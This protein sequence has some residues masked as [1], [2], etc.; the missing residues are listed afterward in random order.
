MKKFEK[1]LQYSRK[2]EELQTARKAKEVDEIRKFDI[3]LERQKCRDLSQILRTEQQQVKHVVQNLD[4]PVE[5]ELGHQA[6][7]RQAFEEAVEFER[8]AH[9]MKLNAPGNEFGVISELQGFTYEEQHPYRQ[10]QLPEAS[11]DAFTNELSDVIEMELQRELQKNEEAITESTATRKPK[12]KITGADSSLSQRHI[13]QED[14][15]ILQ[16]EFGQNLTIIDEE[17]SSEQGN[18]DD[19]EK[20]EKPASP[21]FFRPTYTPKDK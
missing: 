8:Q 6:N 14:Q 20:Q 11:D 19:V 15:C 18:N 1:F 7:T 5:M 12:K 9:N 17:R 21:F 2:L 3:Q 16:Q 13:Q 10:K 4:T